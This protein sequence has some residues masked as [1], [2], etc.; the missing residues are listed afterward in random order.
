MSLFAISVVCLLT[1]ISFLIK[2]T[3]LARQRSH[4]TASDKARRDWPS[5]SVIIPARNE[6]SNIAKSLGSVLAQEYPQDKL[7]VIVVD[8]FS[9]DDTQAIANQVIEGS[10]CNARVISGRPGTR[11]KTVVG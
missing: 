11:L 6:T 7:E 4:I 8:D 5:V 9:E 10:R 3:K 2:L 1:I